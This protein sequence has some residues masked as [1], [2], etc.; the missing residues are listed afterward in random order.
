MQLMGE[1]DSWEIHVPPS[2]AYGDSGCWSEKRG[3]YVHPGA[4][5]VFILTIVKVKGRGKP[6]PW[7]PPPGE[8]HQPASRSP[9]G[10]QLLQQASPSPADSR[11]GRW[12]AEREQLAEEMAAGA[13]ADGQPN[14]LSVDGQQAMVATG[15]GGRG[16]E[17]DDDGVMA[18]LQSSDIVV[19]V[20]EAGGDEHITPSSLTDE[21]QTKDKSK[22]EGES[23]T[24]WF[25]GLFGRW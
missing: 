10:Q 6:K 20:A 5:L 24:G 3:Q 21:P 19:D 7:P 17:G 15:E 16:R 14:D 13:A 1:G 12:A 8:Q 2:M 11:K 25:G 4:V 22:G 18:V 9:P 23:G